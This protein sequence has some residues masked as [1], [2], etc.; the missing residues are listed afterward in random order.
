MTKQTVSFM[1]SLVLVLASMAAGLEAQSQMAPAVV[2]MAEQHEPIEWGYTSQKTY[3]DPFNEVDVDVVFTNDAGRQWRVP[4]FWAGGNEWRVRFAAPAPGDYKYHAESTDKS[5]ADLNGHEGVLRVAAYMGANPLLM[6]GPLKVSANRRYFQYADGT[7]FLWLGDTW[8]DGFCTRISLDEFKTLAAD[9]QAKGFDV[10]Q[11][12]AGLDPDESPFDDRG[13]N[14]G[15]YVWEPG[16]T[17]INPAYFDAA[18]RKIQSLVRAELSPAIVGSWGFYLPL[19]GIGKAKKHWRN[20]VARYG[21]YPVV[22]IITGEIGATYWLAKH[23]QEE[24]AFQRKGTFELASYVRSI[25]PYS[26]L[27]TAHPSYPNSARRELSDDSIL[28]FDMLQTGH[29]GWASAANLVSLL[30]ADYSKTPREPLIVGEAVYEG[31]RQMN[32][33]DLQR[34]AF[35]VSMMNGAAGH[36]YGAGGIWQMN[37]RT[38]PHGPSPTGLTSSITYE[39]TPWNLAMRLPGSQQVGIGKEILM[40]YPWWRF[41][42]HPEWT[43]P[44]G[45]AFQTAHSDWFD[46]QKRWEDEHGNYLLP[47]PAGIPDQIRF[48]YIPPEGSFLGPLVTNLEE[49]STYHASYYDPVT[50]EQHSLG[51]LSRPQVNRV[52]QGTAYSPGKPGW[53]DLSDQSSVQGR[54]P[55]TARSTWGVLKDVNEA[56]MLVSVKSHRDAEA[57]ILLRFHDSDN[58][59]VAVYSHELKSVWLHDRQNGEYGPR[60]GATHV[61]EIGSDIT[62]VAEANGSSA[63]LTITDGQHIYRTSPVLV[64][65]THAGRVGVWSEPL[66]CDGNVGGAACRRAENPP[67]RQHSQ[68]FEEFAAYKIENGSPDANANLVVLNAWR[69]PNL[70]LLHDWVLVL[71]R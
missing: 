68:Q 39:N 30:T 18:D 46:A 23:P 22:W 62:L 2:R 69:A 7:P 27:I 24:N 3:S 58:S 42:P 34:F 19:M 38:V 8:W 44:H 26:H 63:S 45:T 59:L 35:W 29:S 37:G 4:T 28:D 67:A 57:G 49:T 52:F 1:T 50:G 5:N 6:H 51:R 16:F 31:H 65:N 56:D 10:V 40:K 53:L 15:G 61:P 20:L 25:D 33:Q 64:T 21:A 17:R 9:R 12:V 60:L 36:T 66:S 43:E 47:Y 13:N 54:N 55:A 41:E 14:E 32:W 11:I 70:P 48:I 71:E